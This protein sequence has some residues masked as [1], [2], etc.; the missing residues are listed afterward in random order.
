MIF[1]LF[2]EREIIEEFKSGDVVMQK[3]GVEYL[4][5]IM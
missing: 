1:I 3:L 2:F 5:K 4:S